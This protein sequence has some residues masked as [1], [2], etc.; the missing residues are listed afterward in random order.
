[1]RVIREPRTAGDVPIRWTPLRTALLSM[2][3][4]S[5]LL[6]GSMT[7]SPSAPGVRG[8]RI[9]AKPASANDVQVTAHDGQFWQGSTPIELRGVHLPMYGPLS[10]LALIKSWG[11]NL[12][13]LTW[14][15]S[16]LEPTPPIHNQDGTWTH[17]YDVSYVAMV[18][19]VVTEARN[20]GLMVVLG[21]YWDQGLYFLFG[22]DWLFQASY[23]SHGITY[24]KTEAGRLQAEGNF[25]S[26]DWQ[27]QF[28]MAQLSYLST[29]FASTPGVI[30][31]E[32][33]NE[34]SSGTL[35][36]THATTQLV[37]DWQLIAARA[38]RANDPARVVFFMSRGYL[39]R[40]LPNAD[41]SGWKALGNVAVDVHDYFGARWGDG[42]Y[43]LVGS[44][45]YREDGQAVSQPVTGYSDSQ[46]L[47]IGSVASHKR[48]IQLM[49]ATSNA[50]GMPLMIGEFG[51]GMFDPGIYAYL[52]SVTRAANMLSVSW[53]ADWLTL[54]TDNTGNTVQPWTKV[55]ID[56]AKEPPR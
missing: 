18:Q 19:D 4:A 32:V 16:K 30:G 33:M 15:W 24:A 22:P 44:P 56:A 35:P 49:L 47:F 13:R 48:M 40:G 5:V 10:R 50:A 41:L 11:M 46:N 6:A 21:N 7:A 17:V 39:D 36:S 45:N 8:T 1:M 9:D 23:N 52:G 12:V 26:D 53:A 42:F 51:D 54:V 34:P 37:L 31:Y 25:W 14:Q 27:R 43:N 29:Q 20:Q 28:M 38:L 2:V 3:L 55:V